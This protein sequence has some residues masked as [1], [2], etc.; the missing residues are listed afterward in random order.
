MARHATARTQNTRPSGSAMRSSTSDG[1]DL[2]W[3]D[4]VMATAKMAM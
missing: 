2:R 3:K 4:S 1:R